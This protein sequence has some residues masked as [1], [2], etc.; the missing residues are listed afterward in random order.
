MKIGY[1]NHN[2]MKEEKEHSCINRDE[3]LQQTDSNIEK[4]GLQVI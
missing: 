3:L 2:Q 1:L 4:Y